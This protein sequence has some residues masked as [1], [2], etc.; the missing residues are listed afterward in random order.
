M[1]NTQCPATK[2]II[3][4]TNSQMGHNGSTIVA[5]ASVTCP[6]CGHK[7]P[8]QDRI[9]FS[10]TLNKFG[11]TIAKH[12]V[13]SVSLASRRRKIVSAL[14]DCWGF[15][16]GMVNEGINIEVAADAILAGEVT[17]ND[18]EG[19]ITDEIM[20]LAF[21]AMMQDGPWWIKK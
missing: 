6:G 9:W 16:S 21:G 14:H 10:Q 17:P 7:I 20:A 2:A 8:T 11:V 13:N 15:A 18:N 3:H 12:A 1:N 19:A 5:P 4:L